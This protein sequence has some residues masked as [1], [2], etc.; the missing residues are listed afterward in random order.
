VYVDDLLVY[1]DTV[2]QHNARLQAL[3]QRL[4]VY[5]LKVNDKKCVFA[6]DH[7]NFLGYSITPSGYAPLSERIEALASAQVPI[8]LAQV[9]RFIGMA[10]FYRAH[11]PH[12]AKLMTPLYDLHEP[13][14]WS[15][16][17]DKAFHHIKQALNQVTILQQPD[18]KAVYHVYT[19]AS[20]EAVGATILQHS[21]PLAFYSS[22]LSDTERRYSTFDREAL[23]V[24]KTVR[25]YKH[26]LLGA[27]IVIHTDH[28]PLLAFS[29]MKD[30]SPRQ[31]RGIEFLSQF[32]ITWTYEKGSQ[33][34]A[35]DFFSRPNDPSINAT[36]AAVTLD[37]IGHPEWC[38]TLAAYD[39]TQ[40]DKH[41]FQLQRTQEGWIDLST[42]R[43]RLLVPP[44][45]RRTCFD[46]VHKIAHFGIKKTLK[47][48]NGR[49]IWP[50]MKSDVQRWCQECQ[51]CQAAKSHNQGHRTPMSF[52]VHERFH[53]VHI[54]IVGPLPTSRSGKQYLLTMMDHFTRWIEAIP[55][56]N[57]SAEKCAITFMENWVCRYGVPANIISDQGTQFES[58]FFNSLLQHLGIQRQRTTAYHPQSNGAVERSHRTIKQCLRAI[59]E[60][61]SCWET[62][63]PLVLFAMRTSINESTQFPPSQLVFGG[64]IRAPA[65]FLFQARLSSTMSQSDFFDNLCSEVRRC[66]VEADV[67]QP[68]RSPSNIPILSDWVWLQ[69]P[70]GISH[71]GLKQPYTGPYQVVQQ[72]QAVITL[73]INGKHTKVNVDRVKPALLN[74]NQTSIVETNLLATESSEESCTNS[75]NDKSNTSSH[76]VLDDNSHN[77]T[78]DNLINDPNALTTQHSRYGRHLNYRFNTPRY[79]GRIFEPT[80]L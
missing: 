65:D 61:N 41:S 27:R 26:W 25:S 60:A 44:S 21:K 70:K 56:T 15:N 18:P 51:Q 78:T 52:L 73:D 46:H 33:N 80:R 31:A 42:G 68:T 17:A 39:P 14:N 5:G 53:T 55:I 8:N 63:L 7:I 35:A 38:Q 30:P 45:L 77:G 59:G 50:N 67:N 47:S 49:F 34:T 79:T 16:D 4:R 54:D 19:D 10:N 69:Q 74:S 71:T 9:K 66:L 58:A 32:D 37:A 75:N 11:I 57:I 6:T 22:R 62:S 29:C 64:Q 20:N 23:A 40:E 1:A 13:F 43:P 36:S 76:I 48:L 3:L 72:D 24:L 12:F 2:E 28:Q